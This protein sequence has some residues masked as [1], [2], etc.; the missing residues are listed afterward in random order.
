MAISDL[1]TDGAAR[2]WRVRDASTLERDE[3][4]EADVV[5]VGSG[6]GGGTA[7]E[8]LS[9]S[10]LNVL[11]LE[12]GALYTSRDFKA[13]DEFTSYSRLYQGAAGRA[14]S[15][16][17]IPILQ[18]RA[19]G[20]TT[21]VNW[22]TSIRTP[23][24][25]LA[26]WARDFDLKGS[27]A[28]EM[29]PWY[30]KMEERLGIAPWAAE[31]NANN[32]VLRDGCDK[33]GLHWK[34]IPRNVRGCWNLGYCGLGCPVNAKQSSLVSTI[35]S[36]LD[37]G[38][39]LIHHARAESLQFADGRVS[40]LTVHALAA[41]TR[42]ASGVKLTVR[43]R[44]YVLAGGA[45]NTPALL[46]RS[47]APDP[48]QRTGQRTCIHPVDISIA[49]FDK[50]IDGYHGAPQSIYSDHFLWPEDGG[51]GYKLEVPPLQPMLASSVLGR[52][53]DALAADMAKLPNTQVL[54]ALMRDGFHDD[55]SGGRIRIDDSGAPVFDY[56]V[57]EPLWNALRRAL[58]S[59]A[60][61]QFAAGAKAV[62]PGHL[63]ARDYASWDEAKT[64]IA[65]LPMQ[66]HR[67]GLVTAHLMG[68]CAM[69]EDRR[70]CVV[71]SHGRHHEVENLSVFDG[72]MFPSSIGANP[73]L[74]IYG[75]V[76]RNATALA[77]EL[78]PHPSFPLPS[79]EG[80]GPR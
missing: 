39:R 74:S 41:D 57:R 44:H 6:A 65:T 26:Y 9:A 19:V 75:F 72:S 61:I 48:H 49:R 46:L 14:T 22:T 68:G 43:A 58:L 11:M 63:D 56:D 8:I 79:D 47:K 17:A 27:G 15:D 45:I 37:Q 53:G 20:G 21:L 23:E 34:V 5:I 31:P 29:V 66:K 28:D 18:G 7:A 38:M 77:G 2:G 10:G 51:V 64:A 24:Q 32:A 30:A 40:G 1:Y 76:A 71:D 4:L 52:Y 54:I 62:R 78:A 13:L 42:R 35:P 59:M 3:T 25:T 12:E 67:T 60:E 80:R 50:T 69:G 16:G 55:V 33:L 73:Q 36:A 70:R